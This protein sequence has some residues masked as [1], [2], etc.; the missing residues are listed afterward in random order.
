M[1]DA[2]TLAHAE[3]VVAHPAVRLLLGETDELDHLVDALPADAHEDGAE[4]E[5]LAAGAAGVL[6]GGVEQ[7]ADMAARVRQAAYGLPSTVAVPDVAG[8]SPD[9]MRIAV[10]LPAPLGPRKPVTSPAFASNETSSTAVNGPY[11]W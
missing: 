3:R 9:M 1:G 7:Q 6:R 8:V 10:V 11:S 2:E 5:H 4:G